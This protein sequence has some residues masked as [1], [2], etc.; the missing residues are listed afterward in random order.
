MSKHRDI[1]LCHASEDKLKVVKPLVAALNE[2][3]ISYWYDEAEI[4][5]GDSVIQKVNE[6]LMIS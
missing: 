6:G 3:G 4:K 1:F 5:W 2:A